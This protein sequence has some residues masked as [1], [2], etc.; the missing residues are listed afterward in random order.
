MNWIIIYEIVYIII[1]VLVC[2]RIIYD[3]NST[4]K[5]LAYLL[6]AIFV[7]FAGMIFYFSF[8]VNYR[9]HK[10]YTKKL[11]NDIDFVHELRQKIVH[12]SRQTFLQHV[13]AVQPFR[14]LARL[15]LS[16]SLSPLSHGNNIK[17]LVN[18]EQKFPEVLHALQ[19]ARHHIHIEYYIFEDDETGGAIERMLIEKAQQGVEVRF[20]YDDFGSRSIRRK[21]ARRLR[22]G[23]GKA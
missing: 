11:F 17:L 2:I 14:E 19:Q 22:A 16:D 13:N 3:T 21:L 12:T 6:L 5:T 1:L 18:G 10:M 20:I 7:P 4:S 15:L 8:G 23:G 9:K